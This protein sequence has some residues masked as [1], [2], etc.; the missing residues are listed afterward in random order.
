MITSVDA[1]SKVQTDL[2]ISHALLPYRSRD[3]VDALLLHKADQV[4]LATA[5]SDIQSLQLA[6]A[7]KASSS[8]VFTASV[9][10]QRIA[11]AVASLK[12]EKDR[13]VE[14]LHTD[15]S[16]R[17]LNSELVALHGSID[18][19]IGAIHNSLDSK[20]TAVDL[21]SHVADLETQIS[22]KADQ[23]ALTSLVATR[24]SA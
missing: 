12:T 1:Y 8:E 15:V 24:A 4:D 23:G 10:E 5:R 13:D 20:A 9:A 19:Q 16:T 21:A 2:A 7:T 3:E 17:A 6:V 14:A 11:A 22:Q 18:A